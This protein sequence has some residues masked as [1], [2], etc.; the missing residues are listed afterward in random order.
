VSSGVRIL[1]ETWSA[2]HDQLTLDVSGSAGAQYELKVLNAAQIESVEGAE[3]KKKSDGSVLT[4]Q[5]PSGG[6]ESYAHAKIVI[7]FSAVQSKGKHR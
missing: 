5:T 2:S 4:L 3:L 1:S 7:H 6:S